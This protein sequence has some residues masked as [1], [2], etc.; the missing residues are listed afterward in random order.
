MSIAALLAFLESSALAE[1]IRTSAYLFPV[2]ESFHV[3]ALTMV[4]GTIVMVD[5]RLLGIA[6]AR[7]P[8]TKLAADILKWTWAAFALAVVTGSL[9]FISNAAVYYHNL[10]FRMK[11]VLLAIA[12]LNMLIFEL[13][14]GRSVDDWDKNRVPPPACK[15]AAV[16]SIVIWISVIVCGRW[17]GFS[18]Q[19]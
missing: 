4:F 9:L 15:V 5:L 17:I 19:L 7:R 12:G 2:I 16:V 13:T 6:S 11:M 1:A 3:L 8:F 10:Y 18:T 14:A